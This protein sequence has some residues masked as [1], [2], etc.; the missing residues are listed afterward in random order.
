MEY[1][2]AG[3]IAVSVAMFIR[4]IDDLANG[5]INFMSLIVL[6][7]ALIL[8][9]IIRF[10]SAQ[11]IAGHEAYRAVH[12]SAKESPDSV[13]NA[14]FINKVAVSNANLAKYK[15]AN[16]GMFDIYIVDDIMEVTPIEY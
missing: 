16:T 3:L 14:T 15:R 6:T 7:V 1:V 8:I 10:A 5:L 12:K 4:G 2:I 9:P 11:D 13:M